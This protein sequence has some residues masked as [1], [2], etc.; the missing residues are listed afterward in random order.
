MQGWIVWVD[1]VGR[2]KLNRETLDTTR[3][4]KD[5]TMSGSI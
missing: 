4:P 5:P 3:E 2:I 1:D